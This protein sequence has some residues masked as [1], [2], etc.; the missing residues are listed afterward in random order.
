MMNNLF[1]EIY[2]TYFR[3][4]AKL[5]ERPTIDEKFRR[6]YQTVKTGDFSAERLTADYSV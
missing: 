6:S 3:I 2:G 4:V 5:L 1:S